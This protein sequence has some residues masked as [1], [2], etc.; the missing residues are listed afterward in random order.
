MVLD[1]TS[2]S[3]IKKKPKVAGELSIMAQKNT[4]VMRIDSELAN[5]LREFAKKNNMKLQQ[6]SKEFAKLNKISLSDK[7]LLKEIKF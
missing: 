4:E 5:Q 2:N 3:P 6:A 7:K 1:Y